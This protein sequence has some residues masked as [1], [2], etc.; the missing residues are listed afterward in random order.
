MQACV[1]YLARSA[2]VTWSSVCS[3]VPAALLHLRQYSEAQPS[4]TDDA[5][6]VR[7]QIEFNTLSTPSCI[8]NEDYP[9]IQFTSPF[10]FT[11]DDVFMPR[12]VGKPMATWTAPLIE[13]RKYLNNTVMSKLL[14]SKYDQTAKRKD[15]ESGAWQALESTVEA[16]NTGDFD[17]LSEFADYELVGEL[18]RNYT[19]TMGTKGMEEK[20]VRF[21]I[22]DRSSLILTDVLER[23]R[24]P[25]GRWVKGAAEGSSSGVSPQPLLDGPEPE[26]FCFLYVLYDCD[27]RADIYRKS[28][29]AVLREVVLPRPYAAAFRRGPLP[30]SLPAG[31]L[32]ADWELVCLRRTN[33]GADVQVE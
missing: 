29:K 23:T 8:L 22:A 31:S 25:E 21:R 10:L 4:Q 19:H 6:P 33:L 18:R 32:E 11:K 26:R 5:E 30:L 2:P 14:Q 17:M 28:D 15:L 13:I 12:A 7:D 3:S 27:L 1:R 20:G 9:Q 16:Y 24:T